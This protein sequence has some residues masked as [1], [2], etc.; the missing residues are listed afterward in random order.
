M[1]DAEQS[2]AFLAED[3]FLLDDGSA[4]DVGIG[5]ICVEN[6]GQVLFVRARGESGQETGDEIEFGAGFANDL[7]QDELGC[8][9]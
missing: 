8:P 5:S 4:N 9:W 6:L 3:H 7:D 1:V 2:E